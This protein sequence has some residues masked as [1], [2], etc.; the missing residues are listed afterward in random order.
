MLSRSE[1]PV[2]PMKQMPLFA[3]FA[4]T[5]LVLSPSTA[6][7]DGPPLSKKELESLASHV[8][9][10]VVLQTYVRKQHQGQFVYEYGVVEV[11]AKRVDKG[12]DIV[13]KDRAYIKYWKKALLQQTLLAD[14]PRRAW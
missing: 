12:S 7:A 9:A 1:Q 6:V 2:I 3:T 13:V 8:F 4:I 14:R 11:D 5:T 10:G